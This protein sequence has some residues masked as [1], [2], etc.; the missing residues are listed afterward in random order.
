MT[1]PPNPAPG[2]Q[3]RRAPGLEHSLGGANA[4]S[5]WLA[6]LLPYVAVLR[7]GVIAREE[8]ISKFGAPTVP[9]G[10][11]SGDGSERPGQD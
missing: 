7:I 1:V 4:D 3:A 10:S 2:E 6:A 11:A 5:G 8:R 9:T